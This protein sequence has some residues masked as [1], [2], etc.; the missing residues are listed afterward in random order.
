VVTTGHAGPPPT[1]TQ[2]IERLETQLDALRSSTDSDREELQERIAEARDDVEDLRAEL[3]A[4][5]AA[6]EQERI[7]H[8]RQ[9]VTLQWVGTILCVSG[10]FLGALANV[11]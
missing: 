1:F 6:Q 10:A 3:A 8:V 11:A 7:E 5:Q 4:Q 2:R 9:K